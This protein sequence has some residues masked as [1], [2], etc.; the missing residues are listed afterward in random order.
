MALTFP[1]D[2]RALADEGTA[3]HRPEFRLV[4]RVAMARLPTAIQTIETAPAVWRV[5]YRTK[6]M[7][8]RQASRVQ[9]F[10]DALGGGKRFLAYDTFRPWPHAH[11]AGVGGVTT[12]YTA[13]KVAG[14]NAIAIAGASALTIRRGDILG[15]E[16]TAASP[17]R[18]CLM[19]VLEDAVAV[20]GVVTVQVSPQISQHFTSGSFT[21][22]INRPVIPMI[23]DPESPYQMT[24]LTSRVEFTF[25]GIQAAA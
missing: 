16:N 8:W 4:P 21:L 6:P 19:R 25:S 20:S 7:M 3:F 18:Y 11:I 15:F 9:A 22:R 14:Q 12:T 5:T 1:L 2:L 23:L 24:D 17:A 13:S 10:L